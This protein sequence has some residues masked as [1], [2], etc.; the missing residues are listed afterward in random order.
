LSVVEAVSFQEAYLTECRALVLDEL[1]AIVRAGGSGDERAYS[2][3][4][5]YPLRR[6]K[7]LR[8]A[9][10][11]AVARALGGALE[12]VLPSATVLEIYHNAFLIH[13]DIEDGS[14][15]RRGAPALHQ[16]H[17]VP[18]AVNCGDGLLAL[19]LRPLL[20]N[21]ERLGLGRALR[22]LEIYAA[23]VVETYEGQARELR[24]IDD[25]AWDL[26]DADYEDMVQRKTCSYSFVAP[27]RVGAAVAGAPHGV[28][29]RL[30]P[31]FR[32]LGLAFQ[33]QDDLLNLE[34]GRETYGKELAG[35]LWEGKRTLML[36]HAL[37]TAP[38]GDRDRALAI[39]ARPRPSRQSREL[40]LVLAELQAA[41]RLDR[42]GAEAIAL[43]LRGGGPEKTSDDVE[44]L[45]SLV[46]RHEG[47][48][49]AR[50]I[51]RG[52]AEAAAAEWARIEEL[53]GSSVHARFLHWL[54]DYV[55]RREW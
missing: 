55:V 29:Q 42:A 41:G 48:A 50:A 1:R 43:R 23:T 31:F 4:L 26:S 17:G 18:A 12:D 20:D 49:H 27:A 40:D 38:A 36:L 51:A 30:V 54:K 21:T 3:L 37:R 8:P 47:V 45:L 28:E 33:I 32:R 13:D 53:L 14:L 34:Q 19:T 10:C 16:T 52:H 35:D 11:I 7:G 24:W 6:A 39:L 9:L 25:G 15:E 2:T 46:E 22:V 44:F 5:D